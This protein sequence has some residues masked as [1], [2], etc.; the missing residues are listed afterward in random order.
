MQFKLHLYQSKSFFFNFMHFFECRTRDIFLSRSCLDTVLF[1]T[2]FRA[3]YPRKMSLT[4]VYG[5]RGKGARRKNRNPNKLVLFMCLE[6]LYGLKWEPCGAAEWINWADSRPMR[7][8]AVIT[9]TLIKRPA[10]YD[11][12]GGGIKLCVVLQALSLIRGLDNTILYLKS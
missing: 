6:P 8:N 7:F 10:Q 5:K 12:K 4:E 1:K 9:N 11:V 2:L 3:N